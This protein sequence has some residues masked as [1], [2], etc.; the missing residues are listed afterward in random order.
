M[1]G[2]F[3]PWECFSCGR[4]LCRAQEPGLDDL[5]GPCIQRPR[6]LLCG[7]DCQGMKTKNSHVL[8]ELRAH[9]ITEWLRAWD[10]VSCRSEFESCHFVASPC[11]PTLSFL[12]CKMETFIPTA[13][14]HFNIYIL[15]IP[16]STIHSFVI[17]FSQWKA[18]SLR[19]HLPNFVPPQSAQ[20]NAL[21]VG[22]KAPSLLL[23]PLELTLSHT[24]TQAVPHTTPGGA[25]HIDADVNSARSC[26]KW[27]PYLK[28]PESSV[29]KKKES[30]VQL[31]LMAFLNRH[32]SQVLV[33]K[34]CGYND[35]FLSQGTLRSKLTNRD[36][37]A[38][39]DQ[40]HMP[41]PRRDSATQSGPG[42]S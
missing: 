32:E 34:Y 19:Q 2:G 23:W 6:E 25:I 28:F 12:I 5:E 31:D 20:G 17:A 15:K 16:L 21:P 13:L 7:K 14:G 18:T 39:G 29:N 36:D 11:Y 10:G 35:L 33:C 37:R 8:L 24:V 27:Q 42:I 1:C 26:A 9:S 38:G 30:K 4:N 3:P 40:P 41:H 22:T